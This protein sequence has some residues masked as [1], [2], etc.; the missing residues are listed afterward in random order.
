MAHKGIP[1]NAIL[2]YETGNSSPQTWATGGVVNLARD[3]SMLNRQH[4]EQTT[5]QGVPLVYRM[6]FTFSPIIRPFT[7]DGTYSD[8]F[9]EDANSVQ[10]IALRVAQQNWVQRNGCVKLHHAREKQFAIQGIKKSDRGAYDKTMHLAWDATPGTFLTPKDMDRNDY[11]AGSWEYSKIILPNDTGGAYINVVGSHGDEESNTA[12]TRLS[13]PQ[14]YLASRQQV[15]AD[16]NS[17]ADDQPKKFSVLNILREYD[18]HHNTMDEII[19]LVRDNQDEPPYDLTDVNGNDCKGVEVAR[20]FL[21]VSSG[22]QKTV[23]VDVPYGLMEIGLLNTFI[24]AGS[25][26]SLGVHM[27]AE[28]LDIFPMGEF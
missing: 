26:S 27:K 20:C 9:G 13:I 28:V 5:P 17:E 8:I 4:W 23:V 2:N 18:G 25:D 6:A 1:H 21:G 3:Y 12:F 7:D 22:L 14:M 19:D 16:S 11:T 15:E 10:L 24:D